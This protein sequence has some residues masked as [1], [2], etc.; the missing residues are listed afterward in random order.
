MDKIADFEGVSAKN[1]MMGPGSSDL[2]EKTAMVLFMNGGN[3]VSADP[4]Y[5]SLIR[6][7]KPQVV[8]K[9]VPLKA[10]GLMI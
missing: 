3:V 7:L 4:A 8:R 6:V 9:P 1:I 5:M 2:L 10:I